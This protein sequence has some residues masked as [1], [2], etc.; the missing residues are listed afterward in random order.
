MKKTRALILSAQ[1]LASLAA[2]AQATNKTDLHPGWVGVAADQKLRYR[3][4]DNGDRILDFSHAGYGGGGIKLPFA[5]VRK[6]VSP[7]GGDDSSALQ[8]AIDAVSAMPLTG[9]L[10]GAVLLKPGIFHCAKPLTISQAGMVLRGS[11]AGKNGTVIEIT[12]TP[13]VCI[14]IAGERP[15]PTQED[16]ASAI[17]ISDAYVPSGAVSFSVKNPANLAV[18]DSIRIRRLATEA[19]IHFM[20]M[21]TL[22]R[23]GK[24][25]TWIKSDSPMV[26]ERTIR[27]IQGNRITLDIP[28]T[29]A[30]DTRFLASGAATV[31]KAANPKRLAQC[32]IES[33]RIDSPPPSGTLA[34]PNN[35]AASLDNCED[36]WIKDLDMHNTLC[37]IVVAAG[38]RRITLE[39]AHAFHPTTVE[40]GAG[41]SADF[42]IR[43]SQVLIDRSTSSGLGSFYVATLNSGATLNV[44]LNC[45][46]DG[47][48]AIQPHMR[49]ST[50]LLVDS[51]R[52]AD[53][54]IE[55][56]NRNTAGSGHGWA[57]GWAVAWNCTAKTL[58][59]QQPP[60][61]MN[62]CIGCTGELK[63]GS[64]PASFSSQGATV[65][66]PSLYLAQLRERLG[67][68]ALK[69]IGY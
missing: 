11:G 66:P 54:R 62:W 47:N 44:V 23:N 1:L 51:C 19:W 24:N 63:K 21:D 29:D 12:D 45:N 28:I 32:G 37:N 15:R 60:G 6:E 48:G 57:I 14:S 58:E 16:S 34:A 30:I 22:V 20:G 56:I 7:S 17:P 43:G 53:G 40:K 35:T 46:F 52:L 10:R 69:N 64:S 39:G 61:A 41:Y 18:G 5:P 27:A 42:L 55:F 38:A 36:C 13:H 31:V 59:V 3:T 33:L 65:S 2:N 8:A 50:G 9:G 26:A 67:E 68:N 25:Q 4:T 49:W